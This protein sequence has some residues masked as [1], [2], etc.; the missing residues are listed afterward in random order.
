MY[1]RRSP[2]ERL[3]SLALL[4][5]ITAI[6]PRAAAQLIDGITGWADSTIGL[7]TGKWRGPRVPFP[8]PRARPHAPVRLDSAIA[9][10][11]VHGQAQ[12]PRE[13]QRLLDVLAAAEAVHALT[14]AS[15]VL[16]VRGD[17]GEGGTAGRDLY[18]VEQTDESARAYA[19]ASGNFSALDGT[20][21]YA[22]LDARLPSD[23]VFTCTAQALFDAALL[24]LDPAEAEIVRRS[25]AAYFASLITGERGCDEGSE[26][27]DLTRDTPFADATSGADWLR[28]LGARED[29]NRGTF[30][31]QM[32]QFARQRTWEGRDL[33]ASPDLLEAIA[34][35][36][37]LE[38]VELADVAS[39]ISLQ[40][41]RSGR[42]PVRGL[43]LASLPAFL[44]K[45]ELS[46]LGAS[47]VVVRMDEPQ[48][49]TRIR[50]WSRGEVGARYVLAAE[51]LDREGRPLARLQASA[52]RDPNSQ[53]SIELDAQTHAVLVTVTQ[54][55]GG[56][57]DLDPPVRTHTVALTLDHVR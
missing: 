55:G 31:E 3:L 24:E 47:A 41:A 4:L 10:V 53:L 1:V 28:A 13:A 46:P 57:P 14:S 45:V 40:R 52:R 49:G 42:G 5:A 56:I 11:S 54:L 35:A 12:N 9:P 38:R 15:G 37:E 33:R 21:A 32:W 48:P 16:P 43:S 34:K 18:V 25:S 51:R 44:P 7:S 36:L 23:R 30:L 20:R 27:E 19:D 17:A 2:P 8:T 50:V 6:A 29:R 39:E 22:V 26:P